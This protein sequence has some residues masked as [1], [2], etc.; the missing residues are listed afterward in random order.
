MILNTGRKKKK[1]STLVRSEWI[2][3]VIN[4]GII[5]HIEKNIT[6]LPQKGNILASFYAY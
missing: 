6:L 1:Y 3:T 4:V 2:E 5:E